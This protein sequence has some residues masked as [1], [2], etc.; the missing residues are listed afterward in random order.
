MSY[1]KAQGLLLLFALATLLT[2]H[3]RQEFGVNKVLGIY[4]SERILISR[5]EKV[6]TLLTGSREV[7]SDPECEHSYYTDAPATPL[8]ALR[9]TKSKLLYLDV[10]TGF[11]ACSQSI[12]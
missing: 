10:G 11:Y 1:R 8:L 5:A 12:E 4:S 7:T 9:L 2:A 6:G 3:R